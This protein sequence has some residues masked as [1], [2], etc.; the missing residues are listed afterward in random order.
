MSLV[1]SNSF[2]DRLRRLDSADPQYAVAF[3]EQLLAHL[4]A[5]GVSDVHL[6][7]DGNGLDIHWR[8][9]GVLV[10]VGNFPAGVAAN[11]IARLKVLAGLLT[12]RND[13]PQE[14]RLR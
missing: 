3:V 8:K 12:Y 5:A 10:P 1:S 7:P 13:I 9:D 14:G 11:V 6:R 2:V 4:P